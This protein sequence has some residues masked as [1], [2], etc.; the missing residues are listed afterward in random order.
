[1]ANLILAYPNNA[2]ECTLST[3]S[4]TAGLPLNNLKN[5]VLSKVARTSDAVITSTKFDAALTKD[6]PI[7]CIVLVKHNISIFGLYRIRGSAVS[8]F[9]TTVYDSGWKSVWPP[10]YDSLS[11]EWED[12]S[13]W[14]GTVTAE[15]RVNFTS[16]LI[17]VLP[18]TKLAKY[19]RVEIDDTTNTAG[20][21]EIGRFFIGPQ[22]QP[23]NNASYGASMGYETNTTVDSALNGTEYFDVRSNYRNFRFTINNLEYNEGIQ[24]A[25]DASR[26]LGIDKE[27]FLIPDP[28]DTQNMIRRA[29]LGRLKSLS[30]LEYP[31]FNVNNIGFDI[32]EIV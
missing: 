3:G 23:T 14:S 32:K 2:D 25:L 7:K 21:I 26:K 20:Y 31:Y 1:M 8:N 24:R 12:D 18:A 13:F 30:A 15:D 16:N 22:W 10:I 27:C 17:E 5:R 19:W 28:S 4:W 11:L 6:R 29:F 9:A